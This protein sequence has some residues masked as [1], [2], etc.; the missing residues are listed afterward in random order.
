MEK[1][2]IVTGSSSDIG[3]KTALA[4]ARECHKQNN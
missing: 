2:S 4:L 3:F 1:I